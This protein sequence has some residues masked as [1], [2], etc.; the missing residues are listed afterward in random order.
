MEARMRKYFV[1]DYVTTIISTELSFQNNYSNKTGIYDRKIFLYRYIL[2]LV[3]YVPSVPY[4]RNT[5][6]IEMLYKHRIIWN[7]IEICIDSEK[8]IPGTIY[9]DTKHDS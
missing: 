9:S 2:F 4:V 1:F 7:Q 3:K 6:R 5:F 8:D